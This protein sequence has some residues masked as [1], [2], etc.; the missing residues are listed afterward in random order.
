MHKIDSSL[1]TRE[2]I[3]RHPFSWHLVFPDCHFLFPG[4][5]GCQFFCVK[6]K[7]LHM[8]L[9]YLDNTLYIA[10]C[11]R[12][13]IITQHQH[14]PPSL[15]Q[16][17]SLGSWWPWTIV[18][19]YHTSPYIA[20]SGACCVKLNENRSLLSVAKNSC[21][22]IDLYMNLQVWYLEGVCNG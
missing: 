19:F 7:W 8:R 11:S 14:T 4:N 15:W 1:T 9:W 5:N 17:L 16:S 12:A 21:A 18:T 20:F 2:P 3:P 13:F 10:V 6:W 22:S